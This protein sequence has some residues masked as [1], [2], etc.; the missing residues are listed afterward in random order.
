MRARLLAL[1]VLA[2]AAAC[3]L[4]AADKAS[5]A[6]A[7]AFYGE[8]QSGADL[9]RD[10]HVDPALETPEAA[11]AL[12]QL[13]AESPKGA[14]DSVRNT[15]WRY[16][17]SAGSGTVAQLSHD[18]VYGSKSVAVQTVLRKAPGQTNWMIVGFEGAASGASSPVVVGVPPKLDSD[19]N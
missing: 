4:P 5:D 8:V 1:A 19:D 15:G 10:P 13:R 16:N 17:T 11:A 6:I 7:R 9:T 14:P 2:G 3:N 18:Y 12:A